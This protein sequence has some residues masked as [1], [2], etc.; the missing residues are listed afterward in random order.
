MPGESINKMDIVQANMQS[1][2]LEWLLGSLYFLYKF[3]PFSTY[4]YF[5]ASGILSISIYLLYLDTFRMGN[6]RIDPDFKIENFH[7]KHEIL[8]SL[9]HKTIFLCQSSYLG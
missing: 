4:V 7:F 3:M 6:F 1:L 2:F 5:H 8:L 9:V